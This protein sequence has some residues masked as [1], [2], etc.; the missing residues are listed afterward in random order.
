MIE[1]LVPSGV[2]AVDTFE[3][4][5]EP[6]DLYPAEAA[7]IANAVDIIDAEPNAPVP[8]GVLESVTVPGELRHVGELLRV[9]PEI[10]WD[11]LLFSAKE[12]VY[13]T[14]C[15]WTGQRLDF[16]DAVLS[17]APERDEGAGTFTAQVRPSRTYSALPPIRRLD[18]RRTMAGGARPSVVR[19]HGHRVRRVG[20]IHRVGGTGPRCHVRGIR[21]IRRFSAVLATPVIRR[22]RRCR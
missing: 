10:H 16:A 4:G 20:G 12:A 18:A 1:R 7:L 17:F 6:G 14:W 9:A 21:R 3:D 11:R 5:A 19:H 13:K 15:P 22:P 8:E 2:C